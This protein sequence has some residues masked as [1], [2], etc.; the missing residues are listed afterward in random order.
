[1]NKN[2]ILHYGYK[3]LII[4]LKASNHHLET[5]RVIKYVTYKEETCHCKNNI[6]PSCTIPIPIMRLYE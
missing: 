5:A 1:M 4:R 3:A 2:R 6:H